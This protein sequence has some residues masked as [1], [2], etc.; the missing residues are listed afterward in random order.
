MGGFRI[1]VFRR[2]AVT[3]FR[4]SQYA[5]VR[6]AAFP[7]RE[8]VDVCMCVAPYFNMTFGGVFRITKHGPHFAVVCFP[9]RL[10]AAPH[11]GC[12]PL[13]TTAAGRSSR[14]LL[15]A[16]HDGCWPLLTTAANRSSRRL[17]AA[18]HDSVAATDVSILRCY[19]HR[20]LHF[21]VLRPPMPPFCGDTVTDASILAPG[22]EHS[23]RPSGKPK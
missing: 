20:C 18:P 10:L 5:F 14:W 1:N 12:W 22:G 9:R 7:S 6:H 21:A 8:A 23:S 15:A 2:H 3:V 13:L 16:P 19:G 4:P 11:D 17:L